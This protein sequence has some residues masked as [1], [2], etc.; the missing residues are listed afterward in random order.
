MSKA[1]GPEQQLRNHPAHCAQALFLRQLPKGSNRKGPAHTLHSQLPTLNS[2]IAA[3][4]G[5]PYSTPQTPPL[6]QGTE[7][8][9]KPDP[10]GPLPLWGTAQSAEH[11]PSKEQAEET[12]LSSL[13]A[14]PSPCP[15]PLSLETHRGEM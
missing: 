5:S 13:P 9:L 15:G 4:P 1:E 8:V 11:S 3:V 10:P 6:S 12:K 2:L 14:P 7:T